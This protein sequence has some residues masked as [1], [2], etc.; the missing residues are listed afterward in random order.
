MAI[1][2]LPPAPGGAGALLWPRVSNAGFSVT[3]YAYHVNRLTLR[4]LEIKWK[5]SAKLGKLKPQTVI[6]WGQFPETS[7]Y[8]VVRTR[9]ILFDGFEDINSS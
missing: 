9:R 3:I 2:A 6:V 4:C 5:S 7:P 1:Q 8:D